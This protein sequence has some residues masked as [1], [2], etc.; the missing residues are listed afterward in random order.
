MGLALKRN[1]FRDTRE[2]VV[3]GGGLCGSATGEWLILQ[4]PNR[5][6]AVTRIACSSWS[7]FVR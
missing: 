6:F 4:E 5:H 3:K 2:G 7:I 1:L